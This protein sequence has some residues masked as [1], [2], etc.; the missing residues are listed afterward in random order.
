MDNMDDETKEILRSID[1]RLAGISVLILF[2]FLLLVYKSGLVPS[3]II[4]WIA[5]GWMGIFVL[6][7]GIIVLVVLLLVLGVWEL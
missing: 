6:F 5:V 4:D 2:I 3:W 1:R 7:A